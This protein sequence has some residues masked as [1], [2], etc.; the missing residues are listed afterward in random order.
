MQ[1]QEWIARCQN[2][3]EQAFALLMDAYRK[4][5]FSFLMRFCRERGLAEDALQ[6]TLIKVWRRIGSF[7]PGHRFSSWVM[8]IAYRTAIDQ[9][10]RRKSERLFFRDDLPEPVSPDNPASEIESSE[11]YENLLDLVDRLP[12]KQRRIF[13]LR[14]QGE[15]TFRE[16]ARLVKLP[17]NTVL[18]QMR[19]AVT[20]L[21]KQLDENQN[22]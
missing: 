5:L 3:D 12:E 2:G 14:V 22:K 1:E 18:S 17:I 16:I 21:R 20:K 13:L 10:R 19:Y 11:G 9:R 7:K 8:Q 15:M 6:E 4:P